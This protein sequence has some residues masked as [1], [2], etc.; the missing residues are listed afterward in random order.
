MDD[1]FEMPDPQHDLHV[2]F[3]EDGPRPTLPETAWAPLPPPQ[4][5]SRPP[6]AA[7]RTSRTL[8]W[9]AVG[10]VLFFGFAMSGN[11][12]MQPYG[13]FIDEGTHGDPFQPVEITSLP[14][15]GLAPVQPTDLPKFAV[16]PGTTTFR[17]EVVGADPR[18]SLII[19]GSNHELPTDEM[20]LPF[21]AE[22][23]MPP[24]TDLQWITVRGAFGQREIQCRVYV[25]EDLV[26][27]GTGQG[28]AECT[29][30]AR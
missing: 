4:Q 22:L 24:D 29:V 20:E 10:A 14:A 18:A 17:V 3:P 19:V 26:A 30:P 11:Q 5:A 15:E 9:W 23:T 21:A 25:G 28:V 13:H 27:I 16:P 1:Q 8:G 7:P 2:A 6:P 12:A